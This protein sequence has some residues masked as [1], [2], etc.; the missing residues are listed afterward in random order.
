[1]FATNP[2]RAEAITARAEKY[3]AEFGPGFPG[4]PVNGI[5]GTSE[6]EQEAFEDFANEAACPALDPE[7]GLCDL[8]DGRPMTCRVFGPPVRT[9]HQEIDGGQA[10]GCMAEGL[11][12]CELCF[13][14]ATQ[15]EIADAEM[16]V[17]HAEEERLLAMLA[18][19]QGATAPVS[20]D[21]IIAYCLTRQPLAHPEPA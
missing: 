20:G 11:A 10:D 2:V 13:N 17:P 5:L 7:S 15:Q 14:A 9:M 6:E 19:A 18:A 16:I 1:M 8:Y 4:D 21:T 3:L 12:V